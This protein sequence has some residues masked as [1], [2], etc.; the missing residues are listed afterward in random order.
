[1]TRVR[2]FSALG[3]AALL[4]ALAGDPAP[5]AP[6][7]KGAGTGGATPDLKLF[8]DTV[9]K[10]VKA[11]KWPGED[12]EKIM[13]WTAEKVFARTLKAAEQKD[14]ALP[15]EFDKLTKLAVA[16]DY[17]G[18]L[19][20]QY[21]V[22]ENAKITTA[23]NSVIFASGHVQITTATNCVIVAPS[24]RVV[25][26]DNCVIV[27][28]EHFRFTSARQKKD[29]DRS[30]VVAGQWIRG[31]TLT[32][33]IFHVLRPGTQP[34]PDEKAGVNGPQPAITANTVRDA[35][36]LNERGDTRASTA[37][38]PTYLPPKTPIA[39]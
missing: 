25:G 32:G 36:F 28:G 9:G 38:E 1:M 16:A 6:I 31:S 19:D 5:A 37:N 2:V 13:R 15:V 30:V 39:K 10:A 12:D 22:V 4:F 23:K 21:L 34:A 3:A 29:A 20:G 27:A 33:G 24:V 7:P 26:F 18:K 17:K 35:I 11:E 14:R 8:F